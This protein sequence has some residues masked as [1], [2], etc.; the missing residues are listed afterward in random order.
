MIYTPHRCGH[1]IGRKEGGSRRMHLYSSRV[2]FPKLA[3][4]GHL[5]GRKGCE[6]SYKRCAKELNESIFIRVYRSRVT[7]PKH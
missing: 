6:R 7:F 1:G 2:D 4:C 3:R 5:I